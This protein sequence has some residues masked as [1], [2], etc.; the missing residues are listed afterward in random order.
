MENWSVH[1]LVESAAAKFDRKTASSIGRYAQNLIDNDVPVIF[2]LKHLSIIVG[3]SNDMLVETI[4]RR[5]EAANYRMFSI[6]KRSGGIRHIHVVFPELYKVQKFIHEE[7]LSHVPRHR[8]SFAFCKNTNIYKCAALH[9]GARWIF[10]FDLKDFFYSITEANVYNVFIE[11]GYSKLLSFE[12]S[13]LCTTQHVPKNIHLCILRRR[14]KN[15]RL[16]YPSKREFYKLGVLPQGAPSSP[17]LSNMSAKVLDSRL[18][19]VAKELG[20]I[21]TRYADDICFSALE[22]PEKIGVGKIKYMILEAIK[23]SG[24]KENQNKIK[25]AGPGSKKMVL[26]LLVDG[27]RPKLSKETRNRVERLVYAV[28]K[29][30]PFE[31]AKHEGFDSVF[32][33]Q[34]HFWGL[35]ANVK[36]IDCDLWKK[37]Q[38]RLNEAKWIMPL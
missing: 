24:F 4:G 28:V 29:F 9:C 31:T 32:G 10:Q 37:Y 11:L 15:L 12:M 25:I 2:S 22:L 6:R 26:G 27:D 36:N 34:N 30:G 5:R 1:H 38:F 33:F 3:V 35:M 23:K 7:I 18:E 13:R 21:Y 19:G 16:A 8:S 14:K 17:M 20:F